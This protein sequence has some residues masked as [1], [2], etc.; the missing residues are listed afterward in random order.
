MLRNLHLK[1]LYFSTFEELKNSQRD[2]KYYLSELPAF[3]DFL[4]PTIMLRSFSHFASYLGISFARQCK[5]CTHKDCVN[6]KALSSVLSTQVIANT[7]K[8]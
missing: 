7:T 3:Q 1:K 6:A 8:V 4:P 5:C 2:A